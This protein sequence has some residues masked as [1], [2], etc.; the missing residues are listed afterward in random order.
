[1]PTG[2]QKDIEVALEIILENKVGQKRR[3]RRKKSPAEEKAY[4]KNK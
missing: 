2:I 4:G 3:K 1:M